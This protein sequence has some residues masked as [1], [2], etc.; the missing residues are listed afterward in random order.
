MSEI[1]VDRRRLLLIGGSALALLGASAC[2][3]GPAACTD[4]SGL[5]PEE[6]K[7]RK[8]LGYTDKSSDKNETCE[9][10]QQWVPPAESGQC[11]GCKVIKGPV[12]PNGYCVVFVAA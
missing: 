4:V 6:I 5:T 10:C 1:A 12:H 11:G 9:N 8:T 2:N 7:T 3:R